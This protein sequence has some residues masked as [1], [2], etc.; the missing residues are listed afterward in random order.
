SI[1]ASANSTNEFVEFAEADIEQSIV[2]RFE[3]QVRK[4]PS[5]LAIKTNDH[6]WS[7]GDLDA[8]ATRIAQAIVS[9]GLDDDARV[10]LLFDHGA[11]MIAAM[12]GALKAGCA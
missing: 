11:P 6:E 4:N 5:R 9:L 3:T 7:Y 12:L 8:T 10:A 2:S 1:S